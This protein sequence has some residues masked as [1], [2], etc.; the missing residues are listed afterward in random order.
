MPA[1]VVLSLCLLTGVPPLTDGQVGR[2]ET[3]HDG[4]DHQEEAFV[5]LVE[6]ARTFSGEGPGLVGSA[7]VRLAP[8]CDALL[9]DPDAHRGDLCRL[10]GVVQQVTPLARPHEAAT[11]CFVRDAAGRPLLVY[12][13]GLSPEDRDV[14]A[15]G[16]DIALY[17]RFYKR[18][19]A[20]AR[21]GA[22]RRY[23]AFVG[24]RP[25]RPTPRDAA[26]SVLPVVAALVLGLGAVFLLLLLLTR[27][28]R[29]TL[30]VRRARP[31]PDEEPAE[32]DDQPPLPDDP[33]EALAELKRRAAGGV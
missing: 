33:T 13:V 10:S 26:T 8:D 19:D 14:F 18:V 29:R 12:I 23:P 15:P 25:W 5:A 24:A 31:S 28:Q 21:D 7:A 2:L 32:L 9:A 17:A 22:M 16:R 20:E 1:A 30:P 27:R 6:N 3:A 4:R 11:E